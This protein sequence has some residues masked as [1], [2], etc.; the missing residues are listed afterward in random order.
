MNTIDRLMIGSLTVGVWVLVAIQVTSSE[1]A[2]ALSIYADDIDG[3][4]YFVE[5]CAPSAP[6]EQ[7]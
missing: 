3:L 6:M 5:D 2:Y 4:R 7:I 1:P